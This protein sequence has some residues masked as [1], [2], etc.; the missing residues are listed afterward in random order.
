M[1]VLCP[2]AGETSYFVLSD[3]TTLPLMAVSRSTRD[4]P[5]TLDLSKV[6]G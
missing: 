4:S 3:S 6:N 5:V 1:S 2:A